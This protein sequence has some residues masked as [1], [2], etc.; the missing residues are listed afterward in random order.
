M[1]ANGPPWMKAGL[2][3]SVCT[4]LGARASFN[5]TDIGPG[6][7]KSLASTGSRSR[8]WPMTILPKRSVRSARSIARQKMAMTSDAT[9][10]A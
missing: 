9:V 6:A 2:F 10:M 4:R 1:L 7:F 3:S 5:N 8:V